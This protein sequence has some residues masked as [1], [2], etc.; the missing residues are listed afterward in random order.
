MR[1]KTQFEKQAAEIE[2]VINAARRVVTARGAGCYTATAVLSDALQAYDRHERLRQRACM[3]E[4]CIEARG[5]ALIDSEVGLSAR[6][7]L[8]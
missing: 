4:Q 8:Q 3:C 5:T 1:T 7:E 6:E 2:R